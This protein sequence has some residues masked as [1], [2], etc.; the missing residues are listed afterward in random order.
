EI[1]RN[2]RGSNRTVIIAMTANALEGERETC[3]AAGM[4]DYLSKPVKIESLRQ[5]LERWIVSTNDRLESSAENPNISSQNDK[6]AVIDLS[7][8]ESFREF[9]QPGETD[10]VTEL[11]NLFISDGKERL[12]ILKQALAERDIKTIKR[13][14]HSLIGGAGNIGARQMARLSKELEQKADQITEAEP[15]IRE[16]ENEFKQAVNCLEVIIKDNKGRKESD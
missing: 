3:I 14:A 16:L 4:D 13:E 5:M 10:L 1:R 12:S 8:L 2:E 9:Q 6:E 15:L 11:I 7:V